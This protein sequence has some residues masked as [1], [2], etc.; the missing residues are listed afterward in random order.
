M[1]FRS[2]LS[3][4][5]LYLPVFVFLV[6][7]VVMI[8]S[9]QHVKT[10]EDYKLPQQLSSAVFIGATL[11][12]VVSLVASSSIFTWKTKYEQLQ[13]TEVPNFDESVPNVDM[14]NLIILDEND[15]RKTSEKLITEKN[16]SMGSQF[17]IGEGTLSIV[18]EKPY[19][20]FPMEYRGFFKWLKNS[21][22]IPGYIKVSATDF[23][24]SEFVDY[25]YAVSPT[26]FLSDDLRRTIYLKHPNVGLTD[27]SFEVDD[28]GKGYWVVTA[29]TYETWMSTLKVLG[30]I[31]VDPVSK[32]MTY[33][34][35]D[36]QPE[37]VDRVYSME[38]FDKQLNWY[39]KYVNGWW[40][41]SDEGKL[42]DTE[43]MGYVFKDKTL[44]YYTGM[45]SVGKDSATTGFVIFNPKN[46]KA[47]YNRI[48]GSIENKA[49]GL[50]E[51]LVQN[52]GY[53]ANF[54]YLI[55]LNGEATYF[56]T[57]KGNSGNVVG[58]AFASV[59]NYKAVAW[60]QTLREAQTEYSRVLLREGGDN[61]LTAQS[62]DLVTRDGTVSRVGI[63]TDGYY[64]IKLVGD[65]ILYVVNSEQF[66]LVSLTAEGDLVHISHL[67]D[68]SAEKVDA[69]EFTNK[70]IK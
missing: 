61:A 15:A 35:V 69:F 70:S 48:S 41:P 45:T 37:W 21:G 50:M 39:G 55:N 54:P 32:E 38:T 53:K 65:D 3:F 36:T 22:E 2:V 20:I 66:P 62:S 59:Q 14:E 64:I 49:V 43:G 29:Y 47:E 12:I 46:G 19:W 67:K 31:I 63:L 1:L 6:A 5:F 10:K 11:Y 28:A 44:Y 30:T 13:V 56:S 24:D 58:Y 7:M 60:A 42:M 40:N 8:L 4:N 33:Y 51:E 52:A 27:F 16:P 9:V 25:K 26:G 57:L 23:N 34:E 17:Q 18:E 68:S